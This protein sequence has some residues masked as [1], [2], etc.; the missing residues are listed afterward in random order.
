MTRPV[1]VRRSVH[2]ASRFWTTAWSRETTPDMDG[3]EQ[4][5]SALYSDPGSPIWSSFMCPPSDTS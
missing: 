3:T 4:R 5:P 2:A 1:R